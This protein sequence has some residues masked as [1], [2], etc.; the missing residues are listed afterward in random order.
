MGDTKQSG[1]AGIV[2]CGPNGGFSLF[3]VQRTIA[4]APTS[5]KNL[6]DHD[7]GSVETRIMYSGRLA[8]WLGTILIGIAFSV[9]RVGAAAD[10]GT[11][12]ALIVVGLP[13]D[14]E[15][16]TR[17]AEVARAW[18]QWLSGPLGFKAAEIHVLG[19]PGGA[20]RDATREA[21]EREVAALRKTSTKDD[22][23]WVFWLGHTNLD[24]SHAVLHLPGPD[25]TD[26]QFGALFRG[27]EA[28]EQVFWMTSSGSG[29]LVRSLSAPGR[30]VVAATERDQEFNE[31][32][33]PEAFAAISSQPRSEAD[34]NGDGKVSVL[35][36]VHAVVAKVERRFVADQRAPTEHAQLDDD[37][38]GRGRDMTVPTATTHNAA[39]TSDGVLAAKTWL[40]SR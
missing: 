23:L 24:G 30:I 37:G 17:F 20:D 33:F 9:P 4:R 35:E 5:P 10:I 26:D 36:L 11:A 6:L 1:E 15:H 8:S 25:L 39:V 31:T 27:I 13:G 18:R 16:K 38:D 3:A 40:S 7:S 19:D 34:E 14:A 12:R 32:E 29:W 2:R 22:R 28:R 21:I